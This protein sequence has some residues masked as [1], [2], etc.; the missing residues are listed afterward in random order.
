IQPQSHDIRRCLFYLLLQRDF[1]P[2]IAS[3]EITRFFIVAVEVSVTADPSPVPVLVVQQS[4][5]PRSRRGPIRFPLI[6]INFYFPVNLGVTFSSFPIGE[7][8]NRT[9]RNSLTRSPK[10]TDILGKLLR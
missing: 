2:E 3:A 4:Y 1:L 8:R 10:I 6:G 5:P 9:I 7:A